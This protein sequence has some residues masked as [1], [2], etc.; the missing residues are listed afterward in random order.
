MALITFMSDFGKEDHYVA[1][2][3]AK[4]ISINPNI[5]IVDISHNIRPFS[6]SHG[7]Y[8]LRS[9]FRDFPKGTVHLA[10]IDT[11]TR[12][13][14]ALAMKIEEHFFVGPDNGIFSLIS[15]QKP[16]VVVDLNKLKPVE[17]A[18]PAKEIYAS[19]AANL[20]SGKNIHDLGPIRKE[21]TQLLDR[22]IKANKALISGNVIRVDNYGNLITNIPKVEFENI[23]ALNKSEDFEIKLGRENVNRIHNS[24]HSV[25]PGD[26]FCL[27][28]SFGLLE[29]G[30]NSGNASE[31]LGLS[32]DSPIS[33]HFN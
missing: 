5:N 14:G 18:F 22:Q 32:F 9:I 28:N 19:V 2:V 17:F 15:S 10:A 23:I 3:K 24:Y 31:L 4:I 20:A 27:F 8:V 13:W 1:A 25:E 12:D 16:T 11:Y 7:A 29:V 21:W 6:L 30:I 26:C 33:I